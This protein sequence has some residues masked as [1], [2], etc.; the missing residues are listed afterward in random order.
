MRNTL[1]DAYRKFVPEKIKG[2]VR[3]P[4]K[5]AVV[6]LENMIF[7]Y[8][9]TVPRTVEIETNDLCTRSCT[10]CPKPE[11]QGLEMSDELFKSIITQ[12]DELKFKGTLCLHQ[13]NEPL[14]DPRLADF[15][16]YAHNVLPKTN[17]ELYTNGDLLS[18]EKINSL[19]KSGVHRIIATIHASSSIA[20]AK[21]L[22][23]LK[24]QNNQM[25]I[26]DFREGSKTRPF[27]TRGGLV[28]LDNVR[29]STQCY[30]IDSLIVRVNGDVVL[31]CQDSQKRYIYGNVNNQTIQEIWNDD[32]FKKT[33]NKIMHGKF[34]LE[35][36]QKCGYERI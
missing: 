31:C 20:H 16:A 13:Y 4:V 18:Q 28:E 1:R 9:S 14:T 34:E 7:N 12:L 8:S 2:K 17:I 6:I 21:K 5:D 11:S 25:Y 32:E 29:Y 10:Y 26:Q 3:E 15:M 35:M 36:C 33:R 24:K 30:T 22:K 19:Q 23:D 27:S